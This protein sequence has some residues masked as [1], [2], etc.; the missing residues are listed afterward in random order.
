MG[1]F[2]NAIIG[3]TVLWDDHTYPTQEDI[4]Q[5]FWEDLTADLD[6]LR[7]YRPLDPTDP[8]YDRYFYSDNLVHYYENP[9]NVQD[10]LFALRQVA[11]RLQEL[12]LQVVPEFEGIPPIPGQ[13]Q[14][15]FVNDV[16]VRSYS[17]IA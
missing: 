10:I 2:S 8:E 1:Y 14:L 5:Y 12:R 13:M 4:L 17:L 3:M 7:E 16:N 15:L 6:A 11:L 9:M